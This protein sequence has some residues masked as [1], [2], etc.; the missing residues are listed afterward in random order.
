MNNLVFIDRRPEKP[1]KLDN[2][3]LRYFELVIT[4]ENFDNSKVKKAKIA[5][6]IVEKL[7]SEGMTVDFKSVS[8][9]FSSNYADDKMRTNKPGSYVSD[10]EWQS[11]HSIDIELNRELANSEEIR[12]DNLIFSDRLSYFSFIT[13]Y[14]NK[15]QVLLFTKEQLKNLLN[16]KIDN[17]SYTLYK[18]AQ[19]KQ[20]VKFNFYFTTGATKEKD[21][22]ENESE[23]VTIFPNSNKSIWYRMKVKINKIFK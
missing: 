14:L 22:I 19:S 7:K 10:R 2:S 3:G 5:E 18:N 12:T 15:F 16:T 21:S 11:W 17:S 6:E 13:P 23:I 9:R 1:I 8:V 4:D 20:Y